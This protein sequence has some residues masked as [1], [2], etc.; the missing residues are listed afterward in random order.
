MDKLIESFGSLVSGGLVAL[1][2]WWLTT[3]ARNRQDQEG[4]G[5]R[6]AGTPTR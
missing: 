2:T 6:C 1:L 5:K 4:S 3:R